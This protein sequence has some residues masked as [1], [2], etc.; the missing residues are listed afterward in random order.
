[1]RIALL[2]ALIQSGCGQTCTI[3]EACE[4]ICPSG[5]QAVCSPSQSCVCV[6]D[7]V[8][9][10]AAINPMCSPPSR[11]DLVM[12]E[13]L[14]DGEPTEAA[15]FVEVVNRSGDPVDLDGVSLL[16]ERNG[17]LIGMVLFGYGCLAPKATMALFADREQWLVL[18]QPSEPLVASTKRFSLPNDRDF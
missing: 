3:G 18:P 13:V 17:R 10:N 16:K 8:Q 6:T 14:P 1:M 7:Y 2:L 5:G 12:T 11:G 9:T 4:R 15:E